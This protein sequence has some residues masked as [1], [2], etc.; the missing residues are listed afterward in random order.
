MVCFMHNPLC[1][2]ASTLEKAAKKLYRMNKLEVSNIIVRNCNNVFL[3]LKS[4]IKSCAFT[5]KHQ[6]SLV[7][8]AADDA[9]S[10]TRIDCKQFKQKNKKWVVCVWSYSSIGNTFA[11]FLHSK[12]LKSS[13]TLASRCVW[14]SGACRELK[15][16]F[17]HLISE[18]IPHL[19]TTL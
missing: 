13:V 2:S 18:Q 16:W 6:S 3:P 1:I 4:S 17:T 12:Y 8:S 7:I 15:D 14:V 5:R 10:A 11:F 9:C 19:D